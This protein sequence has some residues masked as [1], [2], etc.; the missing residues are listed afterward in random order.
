MWTDSVVNSEQL[1]LFFGYLT[2]YL[3][4]L[5][6]LPVTRILDNLMEMKTNPVSS[7]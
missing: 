7:M 1:W 5:Q 2:K 3:F 6:N 4:F